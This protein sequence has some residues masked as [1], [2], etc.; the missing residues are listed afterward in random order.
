M[1]HCPHIPMNIGVYLYFYHVH[2]PQVFTHGHPHYPL[3]FSSGPHT[4]GASCVTCSTVT[5][6][7]NPTTYLQIHSFIRSSTHSPIYSFT[8]LL[9]HSFI[10]PFIHSFIHSFILSLSHTSIQL[11]CMSGCTI[12]LN[13][14]T[15]AVPHFLL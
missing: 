4:P 15:G 9:T 3:T 5:L 12:V 8:Y 10:H 6:T 2:T 14:L 1:C 11:H 13:K 7:H